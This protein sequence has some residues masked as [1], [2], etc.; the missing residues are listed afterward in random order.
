MKNVKSRARTSFTDELLEGC[1]QIAIAEI[2]PD[3]EK[4]LKQSEC[5]VS[6]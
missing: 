1:M 2:E 4:L 3:I 5:Q 6:H